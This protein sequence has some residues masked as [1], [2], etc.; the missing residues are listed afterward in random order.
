MDW[1]KLQHTL[2]ALDPT[3]PK[4][5]LAKLR[6][7][8]QGGSVKPAEPTK[9]YL[10]E[11]ATVPEGS[12]K[13]DKDYSVADFAALAGVKVNEGP[14]DGIRAG[15]KS[16]QSGALAPNSAE[17]TV[18][19]YFTSTGKDNQEPNKIQ[20]PKKQEPASISAKLHPRL[21][22]KLEPY[23]TALEKIFTSERELK[24][25]FIA[26]MKRADP[27]IESVEEADVMK[28]KAPNTV[29]QRDP[30]WRDMEALRKSGAAGAH[31]DKKKDMKSGKVKHKSKEY[32]SIKE[33]LY[34]KLNEKK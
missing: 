4:E 8:A 3:D 31:K 9:D 17:K 27:T 34:A 30:N 6:Q 13:L 33:M 18:S 16:Y 14:L 22:T 1:H 11:S 28:F 20:K 25:E 26:L 21:I 12:L 29:K 7:A 15:V 5:D 23:K 24:K 32:E 10:N 19:D 2:Y